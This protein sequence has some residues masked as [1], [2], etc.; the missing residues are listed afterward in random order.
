MYNKVKSTTKHHKRGWKEKRMKALYEVSVIERATGE[1]IHRIKGVDELERIED[2]ITG[3]V[4]VR[5]ET[6]EGRC[7]KYSESE[8]EVKYER[9]SR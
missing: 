3:E 5:I 9:M 4:K 1:E 7:F 2:L 6:Y 8:Y